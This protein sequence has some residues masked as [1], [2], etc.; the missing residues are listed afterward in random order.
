MTFKTIKKNSSNI[1]YESVK[2][3]LLIFYKTVRK[4]IKK[5][6]FSMT[7]IDEKIMLT[8]KTKTKNIYISLLCVLHKSMCIC[9]R[10][11][12]STLC[13]IRYFNDKIKS[14][15]VYYLYRSIL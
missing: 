1:S 15:A 5:W 4:P 13:Y 3:I 10:W 6:I 11:L 9:V 8:D 14:I 7:K 12:L 2:I